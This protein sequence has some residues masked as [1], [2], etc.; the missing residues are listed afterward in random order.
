MPIVAD[1]TVFRYLVVLE[2]VEILPALF[3]HVLVPP[4][5]VSELQR[6][7]TPA[8][9]RTWSATLPPW[10]RLQ[11]P[12]LPPDPMLSAL[13]AGEQEAIQLMHEQQAPLLVTDDRE[14]YN[15]ALI[16]GI[17]VTRTLRILEMA[18]ERGLLDFPTMATRLRAA[19][20]YMPED[21]VEEMLARDATR[22]A[23][24][25]P[26]PPELRGP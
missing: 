2:V 26:S 6:A 5:V 19:G 4:A 9:V 11:S 25:H 8:R 23:A 24:A 18:A 17:P 13:G 20:F 22:K 3:G 12:S 16:R 7:S 10:V 14:A 15:T 1:T 21:V